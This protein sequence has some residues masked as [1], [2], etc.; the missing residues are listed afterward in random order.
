MDDY[1]RLEY[2]KQ[3]SY[4]RVDYILAQ[5][6][7]KLESRTISKIKKETSKFFDSTVPYRI[8]Q[9]VYVSPHPDNH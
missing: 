5:L 6:I 4:V 8:N 2:V 9:S 3:F 7:E 1:V